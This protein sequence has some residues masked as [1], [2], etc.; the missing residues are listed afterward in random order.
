MIWMLLPYGFL[1]VALIGVLALF[2]SLK[3]ELRRV[4]QNEPRMEPTYA[5]LRSGMNMER[6]TEVL[7]LHRH[8]ERPGHIAETLGIP[9]GEVE[10]IIRVYKLGG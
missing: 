7:R 2:L 10:L 8:G 1:A 5:A 6:R 4:R 3:R 9:R